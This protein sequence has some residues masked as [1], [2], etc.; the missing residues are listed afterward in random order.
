M[1]APAIGLF[2]KVIIAKLLFV[3][4]LVFSLL[5]GQTSLTPSPMKTLLATFSLVCLLLSTGIAQTFTPPAGSTLTNGNIGS[6]Y[7]GQDIIVDVPD[8]ITL[9]GQ[10]I[11]DNLSGAVVPIFGSSIDANEDYLVN[12]DSVEFNF[13][14]LPIGLFDGC[15][16]C[17]IQ[18]GTSGSVNIIGS[19]TNVASLTLDLVSSLYG[20]TMINN[21]QDSLIFGGMFGQS[22]GIPIPLPVDPLANVMNA[23]GYTLD[24]T[25]TNNLPTFS[26][27][28]VAASNCDGSAEVNVYSGVAPLTFTFSTGQS[29]PQPTINGLCTGN[30]SVSVED[31]NGGVVNGTFIITDAANVYSSIFPLPGDTLF[32]SPFIL[33]DLDFNEPLDSFEITNAYA[34]GTDTLIAEWLVWQQGVSYAVLTNYPNLNGSNTILSVTIFCLNGRSEIG[35]FQLFAEAPAFLS[36]IEDDYKEIPIS[37]FPNPTNSIIFLET[38][39]PLTHAWLTDLTGRRLFK[40]QPNGFTQWQADLSLLPNGIYLVDVLTKEGRKSV[41]KVSKITGL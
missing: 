27:S 32:T 30:Y 6:Q 16:N 34:S 25:N 18:G 35:S 24:F 1:A 40:L 22:Q 23:E 19:A 28:T 41:K 29:G 11:L 8:T 10:Q 37:L 38:E 17:M 14:N 15:G 2:R 4:S 33:C 26:V 12:V 39:V 3:E 21:G 31:G 9:T 20:M 13:A 36:G 7:V 5:L